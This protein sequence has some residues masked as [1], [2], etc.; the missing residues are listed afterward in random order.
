MKR[1]LTALLLGFF[2]LASQALAFDYDGLLGSGLTA[3]TN[4]DPNTLATVSPLINNTVTS[5]R[6]NISGDW[7][8]QNRPA[9]FPLGV[10]DQGGEKRLRLHFVPSAGSATTYTVTVWFFN[11]RTNTWVKPAEGSTQTFTGEA[12]TWI[13]NPGTN[14]VFIQLSSIS[15]ETIT[16]Q[17]DRGVAERG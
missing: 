7:T 9:L 17:Y 14:P 11:N 10:S 8:A 6:G 4:P 16:V 15:A 5:F 2:T 3:T 12:A 1:L 13:A